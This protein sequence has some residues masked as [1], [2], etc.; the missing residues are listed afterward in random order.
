M[1]EDRPKEPTISTS[2]SEGQSNVGGISKW[3]TNVGAV[4]TIFG[5]LATAIVSVVELKEKAEVDRATAKL[6]ADAENDKLQVAELQIKTQNAQHEREINL[7]IQKHTL[8]INHEEKMSASAETRADA[9][10]LSSLV[11]H[12]FNDQNGAEGDFAVLFNYVSENEQNEQIVKNAV[13]A[14]MESPRS[15]E[16]IDLGFRLLERI[17]FNAID[18]TAQANRS[19]RRRYDDYLYRIYSMRK[20]QPNN[21]ITLDTPLF[22]RI[23]IW[24]EGVASDTT[25]DHSYVFA[26]IN[27]RLRDIDE[28]QMQER[29]AV[30]EPGDEPKGTGGPSR[31]D[32]VIS[33]IERSNLTMISEL[34]GLKPGS[35]NVDL[36]ETYL[37]DAFLNSEI[38]RTILA[39]PSE[40]NSFDFD[41]AFLGLDSKFGDPIQK[42]PDSFRRAFRSAIS[43]RNNQS[44]NGCFFKSLGEL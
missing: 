11:T 20:A 6:N 33:V 5:A 27:K 36:S 4:I 32:L 34:K 41:G 22:R 19:A 44:P 38:G 29:S 26:V 9:E 15:L 35:S 21:R 42:L 7:E 12:L 18:V 10:K 8:D 37:T 24:E 1:P 3:I 23:D 2:S 17:G 31:L 39:H 30:P 13:L 28:K 40:A 16:E 43:A 25:L 14:R